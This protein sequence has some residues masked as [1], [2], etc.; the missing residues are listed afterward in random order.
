MSASGL[1][2]AFDYIKGG[3]Y[4]THVVFKIYLSRSRT[5]PK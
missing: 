5:A 2:L 3:A 1:R 4:G